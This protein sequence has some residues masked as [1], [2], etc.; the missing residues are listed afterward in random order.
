[1]KNESMRNLIAFVQKPNFMWLTLSVVARRRTT[2][3]KNLIKF[4]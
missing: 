2:E 3:K 1:M 4:V